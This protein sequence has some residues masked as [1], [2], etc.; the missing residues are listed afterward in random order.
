MNNQR[1][2]GAL[3]VLAGVI[4]AVLLGCGGGGGDATPPPAAPPPSLGGGTGGTGAQAPVVSSGTM[5]KG[6]II[7]N[8]IRYDDSATSVTDDRNRTATQLANGMA[9]K[10]RGR[11]DDNV[12]GQADR[13]DV[14]N[15]LRASIQSI[16]TAGNTQSFVA[17][18]LVVIVDSQTIY[19]NVAGL[20]S[21]TVGQRVEVHGPR[22]TG[23][24][25]R[26]TRVE[27]VGAADGQ[28]E[29]RG[30]VSNV[31]TATRQFTLN[32][33]VTVNYSGATFSPAGAS[34][35]SLVAGALVEIHGSLAGAVFTATQ[36]DLEDT[37]D[38]AFRGRD[39]EKTEFEGYVS[40]FTAHPGS[41]TV[42]GR[43]VQTTASTRFVG[44]TAADLANNVKVE[45]EGTSSSGT[46]VASKIEFKQSRIV[47]DGR[48][49]AVDAG[50]G[51]VVVLGQTVRATAQTRIETRSANGNSTS[52]GDLVPPNEC[53]EV[54]AYIDG[55]AIVAEEMKEPSGCGKELVQARVVA[56]NDTAFTLTFLSNLNASLANASVFRN[57]AGQAMSR[58]EFF[59]A[60]VPASANNIGTLVKVK[61]NSLSAVEEAEIEN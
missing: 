30:T 39:N 8:G 11:S 22:D 40:G 1:I 19:S 53:V 17:A 42:N 9:I 25:V 60:I 41:F 46:L 52:L 45:A 3:P 54:R 51:T 55:G 32:G 15:E 4:A 48:A 7:L 16:S 47:L 50:G 59:A 49:T 21:L 5:A 29:L 23:G 31:V 6:S 37:E 56:K 57:A 38:E 33:N 58:A 27:A 43:S 34:A 24:N 35:T 36:I 12:T 13:V 28:D 18:G 61:G 20:S 44:G 2:R 10:L 14:E 26:A